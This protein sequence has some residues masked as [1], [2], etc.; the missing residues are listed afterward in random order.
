VRDLSQIVHA[1]GTHVE[2]EGAL[3]VDLQV[4]AKQPGQRLLLGDHVGGQAYAYRRLGGDRYELCGEFTTD[5]SD[6]LNGSTRGVADDRLHGR[7][8]HCFQR[9][10]KA[11]QAPLP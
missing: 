3:P 5:T 7:G 10:S 11:K 8:R 9:V 2:Q 1:V 4:L 6:Q